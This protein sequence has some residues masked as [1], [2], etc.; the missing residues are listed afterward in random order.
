MFCT[1]PPRS[2]ADLM[3]MPAE[4]LPSFLVSLSYILIIVEE[5]AINANWLCSCRSRLSMSG[6]EMIVDH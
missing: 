6:I 4:L 3:R 1:T 2:F 5:H